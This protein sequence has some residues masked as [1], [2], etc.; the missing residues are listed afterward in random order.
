MAALPSLQRLELI[1]PG[2][3][4]LPAP[5]LL[6]LVTGLCALQQLELEVRVR[7]PADLVASAL[8]AEQ[9]SGERRRTL[10]LELHIAELCWQD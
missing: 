5:A 3:V 1:Y 7:R 9:P 8:A 10:G 2:T 6:Q 4:A